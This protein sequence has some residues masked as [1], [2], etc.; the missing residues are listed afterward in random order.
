MSKKRRRMKPGEP[1]LIVAL[2]YALRLADGPAGNYSLAL[3]C[4]GNETLVALIREHEADFRPAIRLLE[5]TIVRLLSGRD[6]IPWV[7]ST[8]VARA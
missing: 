2:I 3:D 8:K 1:D 7:A 6:A 4:E 5:E